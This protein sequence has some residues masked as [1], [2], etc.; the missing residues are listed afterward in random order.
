MNTLLDPDHHYYILV[1]LSNQF[2][3]RLYRYDIY[4]NSGLDT[5]S[6]LS[7]TFYEDFYYELELKLFHILNIKYHL[8]INMYED[9]VIEPILIPKV[10]SI[11]HNAINNTAPE[12]ECFYNFCT[13]FLH[14]L[15]YAQDNNLPVGLYF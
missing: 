11:L 5:Y 1:P 15:T 10:I 8:H 12:D 7:I 6:F 14:L 9:E 13:K 4:N 2:I 3:E